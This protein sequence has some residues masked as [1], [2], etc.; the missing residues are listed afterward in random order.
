M[1]LKAAVATCVAQL[2]CGREEPFLSGISGLLKFP[3]SFLGVIINDLCHFKLT[4]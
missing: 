3:Y 2:V 1:G 4:K